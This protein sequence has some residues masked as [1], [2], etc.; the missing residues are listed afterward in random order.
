MLIIYRY[1]HAGKQNSI[2]DLQRMQNTNNYLPSDSMNDLSAHQAIDSS[3]HSFK[4]VITN[5]DSPH[6][7]VNNPVVL[8]TNSV[9]IPEFIL[10]CIANMFDTSATPTVHVMSSVSGAM[11]AM[12]DLTDNALVTS[13]L[14]FAY[15]AYIMRVIQKS[16]KVSE[17]TATVPKAMIIPWYEVDQMLPETQLPT[18]NE[19]YDYYSQFTSDDWDESVDAVDPKDVG[20]PGTFYTAMFDR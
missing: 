12:V 16:K 10:N 2:V 19:L 9:T 6:P 1:S 3:S 20:T 4:D 8:D 7:L 18:R 5:S 15:S 14:M 17:A 13:V 11:L